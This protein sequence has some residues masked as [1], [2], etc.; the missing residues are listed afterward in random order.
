M[1]SGPRRGLAVLLVLG[2]VVALLV[3]LGSVVA[4]VLLSGGGA[5]PPTTTFTAGQAVTAPEGGALRGVLVVYGADVEVDGSRTL[6]PGCR[7]VSPGGSERVV[8]SAPGSDPV[9][10][11]GRSLVPVVQVSGWRP[12][13]TLTCSGDQA[14][15]LEPLAV[16]VTEVPATARVVA[17]VLAVLGLLMGVVLLVVGTRL[18]R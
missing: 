14:A 12:G 8:T 11:E 18:L 15:A 2:G 7:A 16:G 9:Q 1:S 13:D 4:A 6:A 5:T 10:V 17:I 3:S